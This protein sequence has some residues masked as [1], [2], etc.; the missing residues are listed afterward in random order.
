MKRI[1]LDELNKRMPFQVPE[2]YFDQLTVD[3]QLRIQDKKRFEWLPA[4]RLR[5][6]IATAAMLTVAVVIWIYQSDQTLTPEQMLAQ[7]D[8]ASLIDYLD[9]TE[10]SEEELL[11]GVSPEVINDLWQQEDVFDDLELPIEDLD[12]LL[13]DFENEI[14][15]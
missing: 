15:S 4:P 5:W 8:E 9:I 10:L 13:L 3:I 6:A 1:K 2:G 11:E 12:Q 7:V 14:N